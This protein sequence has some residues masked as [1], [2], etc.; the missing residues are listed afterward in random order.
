MDFDKIILTKKERFLLFAFRFTKRM[1][2]NFCPNA[3][4]TLNRNGFIYYNCS[5]HQ[6]ELG[7]FLSDGTCRISDK[8]IRYRIYIRRERFHRFLTPIVVA[9]ITSTVLYI[10]Q[11]L[12]LPELSDW[13]RGLF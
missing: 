8:G 13:L 9:A 3:L 12:L 1:P 4:K 6:D 11:Q 5:T 10:S 2:T 7:N